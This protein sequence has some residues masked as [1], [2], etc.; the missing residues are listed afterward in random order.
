MSSAA[1]MWVIYTITAALLLLNVYH[2]LKV[3]SLEREIFSL[4]E[5][6][7]YIKRQVLELKGDVD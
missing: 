1:W 2:Y 7:E 4:R 5:E 6:S 3:K